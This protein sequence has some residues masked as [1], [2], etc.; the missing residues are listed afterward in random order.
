M[1][2]SSLLVIRCSWSLIPILCFIGVEDEAAKTTLELNLYTW[3]H[4]QSVTS[5]ENE[6]IDLFLTRFPFF[7]LFFIKT[8]I[9]IPQSKLVL[10]YLSQNLYSYTLINLVAMKSILGFVYLFISIN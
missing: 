4:P 8:C 10:V 7:S 6:L 3:Q 9:G 2:F 1:H 5:E